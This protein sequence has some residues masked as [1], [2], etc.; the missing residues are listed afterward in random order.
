MYP[1]LSERSSA[2][3]PINRKAGLDKPIYSPER[4]KIEMPLDIVVSLL[5]PDELAKLQKYVASYL[6]RH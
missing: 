1:I 3:T 5:R 2:A 4:T 6:E